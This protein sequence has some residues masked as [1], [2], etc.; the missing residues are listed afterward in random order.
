MQ[1]KVQ[2][3]GLLPRQQQ[4]IRN[5]NSPG[6]RMHSLSPLLRRRRQIRR[7]A[8]RTAK[9]DRLPSNHDVASLAGIIGRHRRRARRIER[10]RRRRVPIVDHVERLGRLGRGERPLI[11]GI[12]AHRCRVDF[13]RFEGS[14]GWKFRCRRRRRSSRR[15]R[16]VVMM[17]VHVLVM[18]HV[19]FLFESAQS[20]DAVTLLGSR[21]VEL[22]RAD[23]T[24]GA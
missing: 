22:N 1:A 5:L 10:R 21:F 24:C 14:L 17:L 8:I 16:F 20:G 9:F 3:L 12:A 4:P 18:V 15:R 11:A 2:R 13:V 7:I 23:E 19:R 6:S